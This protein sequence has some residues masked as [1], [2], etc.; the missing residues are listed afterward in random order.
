M[1]T[2]YVISGSWFTTHH[3]W[4]LYTPFPVPVWRPKQISTPFWIIN[5]FSYG[6]IRITIA[7]TNIINS[8]N[9]VNTYYNWD[10]ISGWIEEKS[11]ISIITH[12]IINCRKQQ[13]SEVVYTLHVVLC[14][15]CFYSSSASNDKVSVS[16]LLFNSLIDFMWCFWSLFF[17]L[18]DKSSFFSQWIHGYGPDITR[19]LRNY[20]LTYIRTMAW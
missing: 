5:L 20:F 13:Q 10:F 7:L 4:R 16:L 9:V 6:L 11:L 2:V 19:P 8:I 12:F 15:V 14:L 17:H 1:A 18:A 3:K